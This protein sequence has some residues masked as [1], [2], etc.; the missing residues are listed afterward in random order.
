MR[1]KTPRDQSQHV[2]SRA[3]CTTAEPMFEVSKKS[4]IAIQFIMSH[5]LRSLQQ[6]K[7]S[8]S[9][10]NSS[11]VCASLRKALSHNELS[12]SR[13]LFQNHRKI[14]F[15]YVSLH[16]R[17]QSVP[18]RSQTCFRSKIQRIE[19]NETLSACRRRHENSF[20][21]K[22]NLFTFIEARFSAM[23]FND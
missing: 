13:I 3:P 7:A 12:F 14:K 8:F 6:R 5:V 10:I 17:V 11:E 1:R 16:R 19:F 18:K 4:K 23:V 2:T 15:T 9:S 21:I 22:I 20:D